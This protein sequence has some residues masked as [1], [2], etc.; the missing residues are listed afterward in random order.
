MHE[1]NDFIDPR[2]LMKEDLDTIKLQKMGFY[3]MYDVYGRQTPEYKSKVIEKNGVNYFEFNLDT[4][5][6]RI[7]FNKIRK[8]AFD[9]KLPIINAYVWWMKLLGGKQN[10]NISKQLEYTANQLNLAAYDEP[11]VD[12]EFKDMATVVAA[13]KKISTFGML[14][15]KPISLIK[16]MTIGVMKGASLA[17]TQIYGKDQFGIKDLTSAYGKLMTIDNK[18]SS[19]FNLIDKINAYYRF[20]NMDVNSIAKKLQTDRRG[21]FRGIGR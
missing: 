7:A 6:H 18:F 12:D 8:Q 19:E 11:I 15:F 1:I 4:I 20:A 17:A 16:E 21:I 3:E 14:A 10:T 5:A 9:R 2:E 13:V